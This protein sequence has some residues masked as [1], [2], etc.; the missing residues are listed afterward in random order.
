MLANHDHRV[1]YCLIIVAID[2]CNGEDWG[3][4]VAWT[5]SYVELYSVPS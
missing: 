1:R 4:H 3:L 2:E 5:L